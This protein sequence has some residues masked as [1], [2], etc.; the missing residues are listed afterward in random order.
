[1]ATTNYT[2]SGNI[3]PSRFVAQSGNFTVAQA[4]AASE[5]VGISQRGVREAPIPGGSAFAAISGD[6]LQVYQDGEECLVSSGAAL[7]A[8]ALVRSDINGQAVVALTATNYFA[9]V[10]RATSAAGELA[11]VRIVRGRVT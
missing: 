4:V 5:C 11:Q 1:M 2:A 6:T 3:L 10:L 8:G 7:P 9:Q